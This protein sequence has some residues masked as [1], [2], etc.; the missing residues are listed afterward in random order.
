MHFFIKK[1]GKHKMFIVSLLAESENEDL[2][3][4]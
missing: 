4:V 3:F 1:F 2:H